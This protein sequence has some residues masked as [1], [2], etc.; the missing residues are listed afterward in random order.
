MDV[1][2][3]KKAV[4]FAQR[5]DFNTLDVKQASAAIVVAEKI[6]Q[7]ISDMNLVLIE[8]GMQEVSTHTA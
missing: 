1:K 4:K 8:E 6:Q 2:Q 7:G 3:L 5:F